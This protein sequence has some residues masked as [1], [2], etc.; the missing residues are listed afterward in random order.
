LSGKIKLY[1]EIFLITAIF[2]AFYQPAGAQ[3]YSLQP[4]DTL[5]ITVLYYPD[6]NKTVT[7]REDYKIFYPFIHESIDVK[8]RD[9]AGIRD[10]IT[11]GLKKIIKDPVVTVD[12]TGYAILQVYV[13]GEVE[14]PG[15]YEVKRDARLLDVLVTAGYKKEA[16]LADV[17]VIRGE[18]RFV[19]DVN[20]II[21]GQDMTQNIPLIYR[22]VIHVP[23]QTRKVS[24][25]GYVEKPGSYAITE[26]MHTIIDA[27]NA[28]GGLINLVPAE[29][30]IV[31][32]MTLVRNG[33]VALTEDMDSIYKGEYIE[34]NMELQPGDVILVSQ[35]K[36][37][38]YVA[39]SGQVEE[40][41]LYEIQEGDRV[42]DA[43]LKAGGVTKEAIVDKATVVKRTGEEIEINI[44]ELLED[45][46]MELNI[47]VDPGDTVMVTKPGK[48]VV[49]AG[50]VETPGVYSLEE[51][52]NVLDAL[53][54]AGA[55]R[56]P[57]LEQIGVFRNVDGQTASFEIDA[58]KLFENPTPDLNIA[59]EK[60][61][62]IYIPEAG[63][64]DPTAFTVTTG[65]LS[66]LTSMI[67]FLTR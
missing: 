62:V 67:N 59:L 16:D 4:G 45:G 17:S 57:D 37:K 50:D 33:Q 14:N 28:A 13:S 58:E 11:E 66:I 3:I 44:E 55:Y 35:E 5:D 41:G 40:P 32:K 30:Y 54:M 23:E 7:V 60:G 38:F 9:L 65:L 1:I 46:K 31:R 63:K 19:I 43:I 64:F 8:E 18:K 10:I 21:S 2:F 24:V 48:R 29:W 6:F 56:K 42:L 27:I 34:E 61:D 25:T 22:D 36:T 51:N 15:V 39:V 49:I 26:E 53:V 47:P 20:K 12:V 52:A